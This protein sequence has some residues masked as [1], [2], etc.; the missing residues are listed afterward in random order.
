MRM[1][2][3]QPEARAIVCG[4]NVETEIE[5]PEESRGPSKHQGLGQEAL[6]AN[7]WGVR[8]WQDLCQEEGVLS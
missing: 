3:T 6:S 4:I 8:L 1:D 7:F 2:Q 5:S